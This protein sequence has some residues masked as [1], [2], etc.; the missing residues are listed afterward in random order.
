M[1]FMDVK[2]SGTTMGALV[3]TEVSDLFI[4][5]EAAKKLNLSVEKGKE[6]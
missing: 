5:Q 4:S 2:I 1:M 6:Q 3:D